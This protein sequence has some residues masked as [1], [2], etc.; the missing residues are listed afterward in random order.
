[1]FRNAS[2]I[3]NQKDRIGLVGKNGS[4]KTTLLRV[5]A[6]QLRADE[7]E[8]I[9]PNGK[10]FGYLP[11]E[12]VLRNDRTVME[13]A[14]TAFKEINELEAGIEALNREIT[15]REDY[16]S[17]KYLSLMQQLTE[18][19]DKFHI[20]GGLSLKEDVEKILTGLGFRPSD[21]DRPLDQ[22][23]YGWQMRVEIAK[24]LLRKP[25]LL[26]L[27][28]PTN[29]L[30]IESIQWL[31]EFLS[32]Y[33]GA[34]VVVSHDR[35]FLDNVTIRTVEIE[36]GRIFDYK[37]SYS[38][39]I[40]M[41]EA[42]LESQM[43][44]LNNQQRQIR[45]IERFIERFRYKNTKSRQV[46]SR[47]KMLQ[48]LEIVEID[49][50]DKSAI[51]FR[52]PVAQESGKVVAE[53]RHLVIS[54]GQLMVLD[55]LDLTLIK[56]DRIAFV[57]KNGEGKTTL[58]KIL[59]GILDHEG[60]LRIGYN[61]SI[62]YYAQNP[63]EML[64]PEITVFD[65]IDKIAVGDVRSKIRTLLGGFLFSEDDIDKKVKVLSGGEKARLALARLLLTPANF[66][67]LDEPTNHLDMQS[68]DILKSALLQ[69]KGTLVVVSH[70]RDFLQGLTNK[71]YEFRNKAVKE[72]LGDIYDFLE[73]R[74]LAS[75]KELEHVANGRHT[76]GEAE[77][78][79][80]RAYYENRKQHDRE[81]RKLTSQIAKCEKEIAALELRVEEMDRFLAD[82]ALISSNEERDRIYINY[83][84]VK[85]SLEAKWLEL[86][87]LEEQLKAHQTGNEG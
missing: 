13:E 38:A 68:K 46:Q 34:A 4:G 3:I 14:V 20:L 54:Y 67:V 2:F 60:E 75:L 24:I 10:T 56:G 37:A 26:L 57:G 40:D 58:S 63:A 70:D 15:Q 78:T 33:P 53:T 7:G 50:F 29:H 9:I 52:F 76:G 73:A 65:T 85:L 69:F 39:Y 66:L 87:R 32:A 16:H 74:K 81:G 6:G 11:Q 28:E 61:V 8:V 43:A 23:S 1:M 82:P 64:D 51:H 21:F 27:D 5:I 47:L 22:F 77:T 59:A 35:A 44:A 71:V 31:E 17:R 18:L 41:R 72:Y 25:D 80:S 55:D 84:K 12:M 49:D 48:K 79:T 30:D 19:N 86:T 83:S 36:L 42:R 45:Q 62:G